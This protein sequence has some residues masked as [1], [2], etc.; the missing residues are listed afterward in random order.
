MP[1]KSS[2]SEQYAESG[3]GTIRDTKI[4]QLY[5]LSDSL[6]LNYGS[7]VLLNM[8]IYS[9]VH[10]NVGKLME[11]KSKLESVRWK[12]TAIGQLR[13]IFINLLCVLQHCLTRSSYYQIIFPSEQNY[14]VSDRAM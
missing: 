10:T 2:H 13:E 9:H 11:Q 8:L 6:C 3:L 14:L 7:V 5:Q 1:Q 12:K 4:F